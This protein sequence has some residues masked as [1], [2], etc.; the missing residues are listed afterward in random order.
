MRIGWF[1]EF[2]P[3]GAIRPLE[4]AA[5]A[6][7]HAECAGVS[8]P[9]YYAA[10][11]QPDVQDVPAKLQPSYTSCGRAW[12]VGLEAASAPATAQGCLRQAPG[13]DDSH[14]RRTCLVGALVK[15]ILGSTATKI[16][17]EITGR[18]LEL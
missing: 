14:D 17:I 3:L 15:T 16:M 2:L 4:R 9:G 8:G 12:A 6:I 7:T 11:P 1:M 5:C 13:A 10:G 18:S